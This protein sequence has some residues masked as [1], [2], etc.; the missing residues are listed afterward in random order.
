MDD[1]IKQLEAELDWLH[2]EI[3]EHQRET[4][5]WRSKA[6]M[7]ANKIEYLEEQIKL[8]EAQLEQAYH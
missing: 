6:N 2:E 1:K 5:K 3:T 7:R 4:N 8:L